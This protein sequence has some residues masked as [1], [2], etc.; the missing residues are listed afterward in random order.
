MPQ[1]HGRT[2]YELLTGNPPDI[3]EFLEFEWYKP[4]WYFEPSVFLHQEKHL[5]RWIGVAHRIG[6][7]MCYWVLPKSGVPIARTTIQAISDQEINTDEIKSQPSTLDQS[8]TEKLDT[9]T[10]ELANFQLVRED[11]DD[12]NDDE[13]LAQPEAK[14]IDVDDIESDIYD[15]LLLTEPQLICEGQLMRATIIGRKRDQDGNLVGTYNNNPLLNTRIYLAEFPDGHV[16]EY[17]AN[18]IA[19]AM[20]DGVNN[21]GIETLLFDQ[22]IGHE[23]DRTAITIQEAKIIKENEKENKEVQRSNNCHL[24]FTTKGWRIC[25]SWKDGSTSWH[26]LADIKNSYP[27]QLAEYAIQ[28][29]LQDYP[30]FSWWVKPTLKR[31]Q[32]FIHTVKARY[33]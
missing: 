5:G 29:K 24:L 19:E 33:A 6:Q 25:I 27:I 21:E 14:A 26:T 32:S 28:N 30:A 15:K 11:K 12:R 8:I 13:E 3:S 2:P 31:K 16:M 1:L 20:Y 7:A 18:V 9:Y 10:D 17:S 4:I 22:I 23:Q